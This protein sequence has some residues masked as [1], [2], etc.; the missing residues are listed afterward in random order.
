MQDGMG[1]CQGDET[2]KLPSEYLSGG[3]RT[4]NCG[5]M[6]DK[7]KKLGQ[8]ADTLQLKLNPGKPSI[9]MAAVLY[10]R[11]PID[12]DIRRNQI[13][14]SAAFGCTEAALRGRVKLIR[15]KLWEAMQNVV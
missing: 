10:L 15:N 6:K 5:Q 11:M 14:I 3:L 9:T 2:M 8:M 1:R 7:A 12:L 4:L 13:E